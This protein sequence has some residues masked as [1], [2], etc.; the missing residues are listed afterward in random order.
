VP[1]AVGG[2][3]AERPH[4]TRV[5]AIVPVFNGEESLARAVQS[6]LEQRY[7]DLEILLVDDGS[8]DGSPALEDRLAS[9]DARVRTL[10][11]R[12]NR[13]LAPTLNTGLRSVDS[14]LVLL[15]HQDCE[16]RGPDWIARAVERLEASGAT[17]V[18][19]RAFHDVGR[20]TPL[21]RVFWVVRAHTGATSLA[22]N[23]HTT[24]TLF[25]ENKCDLYRR[26]AL[27]AVGGFDESFRTGGEDQL[28]ALRLAQGGGRVLTP[29]DLWFD[30]TLGSDRRLGRGIHK[31]LRYGQQMRSVL[32]RSRGRAARRSESGEWDPRLRNRALGVG[33]VISS[34]ALVVVGLALRQPLLVLITVIPPLLRAGVL[35]ARGAAERGAYALRGRDVLGVA[36]LGVLLD[37]VYAVGLVTPDPRRGPTSPAPARTPSAPV[38]SQSR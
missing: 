3:S 34:L 25:S 29:D 14:P 26:D 38:R 13:G 37:V 18:L 33:W 5:S 8:S 23:R 10:R 30:L 16:L 15:L 4:G 7:S 1:A 17:G 19:G 31:E 24:L 9:D 11:I 6:L 20:M 27:L 36:A 12:E 35:A 21:E 22:P 32:L 28:L 2:A